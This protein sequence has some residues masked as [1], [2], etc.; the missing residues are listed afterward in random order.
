MNNF[1]VSFVYGWHP[2]IEGMQRL[3]EEK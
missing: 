3:K 1:M 2:M